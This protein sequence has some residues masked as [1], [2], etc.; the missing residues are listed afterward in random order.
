MKKKFLIVSSFVFTISFISGIALNDIVGV[1]VNAKNDTTITSLP[2]QSF[3]TVVDVTDKRALFI[4]DSHT[5]NHSWGWQVLLCKE[6]GLLMN[7]TAIIGK[8]TPWMLNVAKNSIHSGIDYCFIYG[9]AND[10]HGNVNP[11]K[12]VGNIQKIVDICNAKKVKAVVLTGFDAEKCVKPIRGQ[13][14]YPKAYTKYQ[15]ILMDSIRGA[16]VIDTRVVV[17]TDCGDWTCHMKPS[18]HR[19]VADA[20]IKQMKFKNY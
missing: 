2:K 6:T 4:G 10:I 15:R 17:R 19:K 14:F 8:H 5:S 11:Y 18:G 7:N 1:N 16:K 20:V 12:V 9:G 13:E 3:D